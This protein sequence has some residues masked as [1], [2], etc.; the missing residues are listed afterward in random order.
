MF[1]AVAFYNDKDVMLS[2]ASAPIDAVYGFGG[3]VPLSAAKPAGSRRARV[4]VWGGSSPENAN[5]TAYTDEIIL[6]EGE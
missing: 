5:M 2:L 3:R 6:N 4:F 1:V